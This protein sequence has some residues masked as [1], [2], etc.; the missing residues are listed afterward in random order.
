MQ[1]KYPIYLLNYFNQMSIIILKIITNN[2]FNNQLI[3]F[4]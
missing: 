2:S 1:Y 4:L 3:L